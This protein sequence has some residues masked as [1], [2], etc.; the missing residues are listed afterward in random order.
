MSSVGPGELVEM[1]QIIAD[2]GLWNGAILSF[3]ETI[4][5]RGKRG[6]PFYFYINIII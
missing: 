3:L 6:R 2:F 5:G 4:R 1:E